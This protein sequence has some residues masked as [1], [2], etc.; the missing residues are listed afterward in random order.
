MIRRSFL[1]TPACPNLS[2]IVSHLIDAPLGNTDLNC[3]LQRAIEDETG[4]F[5]LKLRSGAVKLRQLLSECRSKPRSTCNWIVAVAWRDERSRITQTHARC[6]DWSDTGARI[7][8]HQPITLAAPIQI[9]TDGMQRTGEVRHCT[10]KAAEYYVG[11]E[12][13]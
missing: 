5:I 8:Y 6:V 1:N 2:D 3:G 9:R 11:I 7:V 4:M 10:K 12:F 13:L